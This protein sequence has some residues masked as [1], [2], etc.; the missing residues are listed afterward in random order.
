MIWSTWNLLNSY[1]NLMIKC[2]LNF[3]VIMLLYL[4]MYAIP[5]ENVA[6]NI[7]NFIFLL[8]R[9][10]KLFIM[11]LFECVEKYPQ[12]GPS[13]LISSVLKILQKNTFLNMFHN[14]FSSD[15]IFFKYSLPFDLR[16]MVRLKILQC[17][18][19]LRVF[20]NICVYSWFSNMHVDP[21][22]EFLIKLYAL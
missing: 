19:Y 22:C 9:H 12:R 2:Y 20:L 16:L 5:Y 17:F 13:L 21:C 3:S 11:Y 7:I 8:N 4:K 1:L 15:I 6:I 14:K 10:E 18:E